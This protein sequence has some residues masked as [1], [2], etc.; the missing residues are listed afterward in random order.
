MVMPGKKSVKA[1]FHF[2][3]GSPNAY[4]AHLV[5][6][7]IEE[8]TGVEFEYVPV[9]LGGVFKATGNKSPMESLAGIKN[10]PAY[11]N[12][13]TQRFLKRHAITAYK[14]NPHFPVNTLAIMRGAIAAQETGAFEDYVAAV[15]RAMWAEGKKMDDPAVIGAVLAGAGLDARALMALTQEQRVK[16]KLAENTSASV[17]RGTFGSPTFFVGEDIYFGKDSLRDVEEAIAAS[18]A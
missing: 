18:K 17:A 9:L 14:M 16:D 4:L 2:D 3:F 7:E 6:P 13:E 12:L 8:R 1:E 5:L 15:Y 11:Q 10:K